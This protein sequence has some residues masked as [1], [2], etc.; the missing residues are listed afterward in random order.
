M[1]KCDECMF[2]CL[3]KTYEERIKCKEFMTLKGKEE[4]ENQNKELIQKIS[5][6]EKENAE[7]NRDKTELVNSVTELKIKVTE[8]KIKVTEL[9]KQIEKM[10]CCGN[11]NGII[12]GIR[13]EK[14]KFCMRSK[15]LSEWELSE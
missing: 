1:T 6:L 8:L 9:E 11:C 5:E 14:C 15:L 2:L 3:E 4:L 7:L 12:N 10:K 13:Q